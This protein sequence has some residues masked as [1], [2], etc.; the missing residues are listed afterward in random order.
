[1]AKF[2]YSINVEPQDIPGLDDT[3]KRDVADMMTA[4]INK[5]FKHTLVIAIAAL[6]YFAAFS[7]FSFTFYMRMH[8]LLPQLPVA[9][10]LLCIAIVLLEFVAG[11]MNKPALI[12]VFICCFALM[13]T[14]LLNFATIWLA[15]FAFYIT[16][17]NLKLLTLVPMYKAI[18]AEPGY[19]EFTSLPTKDE[20]AKVKND[21]AD[22]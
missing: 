15:P 12:F 11:T 9:M 22:T 6:A 2:S 8:S 16:L 1:M 19:P 21:S 14:L 10:P 13:F 17:I 5:T 7:L 3:H 18:S 4:I 20:V